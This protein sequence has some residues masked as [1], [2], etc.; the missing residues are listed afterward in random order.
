ME[1]DLV[2]ERPGKKTALIEI[3]STRA[4]RA[5]ALRSFSRLSSDFDGCESYCLS[6][7]PIAQKIG[8]I[9]ARFWQTGLYEI[10]GIN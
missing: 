2:I 6:Q 10:L 9:K 4:L 3:K 8:H 1:I 5:E 7:D